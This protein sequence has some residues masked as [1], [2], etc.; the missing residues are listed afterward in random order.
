M[1]LAELSSPMPSFQSCSLIIQSGRI[2]ATIMFGGRMEKRQNPSHQ[3]KMFMTIG[4]QG[5][6]L[7]TINIT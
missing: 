6:S 3:N 7:Y 1:Q 4:P 5:T 2:F